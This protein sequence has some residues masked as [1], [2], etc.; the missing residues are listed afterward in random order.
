[1]H[2][3]ITG[4][5]G[6]IG[7]KL[8][9]RLV[10]E[11]M[12]AGHVISTLTLLDIVAPP[13]PIDFTG[14]SR[15]VAADLAAP[16]IAEQAVADRPEIVFHLAAVVSGEAEADFERAIASIWTARGG[17]SRRSNDMVPCILGL[18]SP[19][20]LPLTAHRFQT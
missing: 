16:G 19:H 11:G 9:L 13:A 10:E 4:A 15:S 20:Q 2:I 6:M 8:V 17:C 3:L 12:L 5:A 7:R 1:M 14:T 18:C